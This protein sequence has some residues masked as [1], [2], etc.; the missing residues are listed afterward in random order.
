MEE[1]LAIGQEWEGDTRIVLFVRLAAG[2]MLDDGLRDRIRR[3]I[4]EGASPRHAPAVILEVADI[5][6]TRF[7]KIVE[8]AVRDAVHGRAIANV[9]AL[10]NPAA[11]DHFRNHPELRA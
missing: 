9:E 11:L 8:L 6:R 1:A 5:P 4:R 10:E 2:A 3:R 7:G